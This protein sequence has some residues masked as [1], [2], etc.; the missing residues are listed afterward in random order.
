MATKN[1]STQ[2]RS[3]SKVTTKTLPASA[4]KPDARIRHLRALSA[5]LANH[6]ATLFTT[7]PGATAVQTVRLI[8]DLNRHESRAETLEDFAAFQ[9][10]NMLAHCLLLDAAGEWETF[11][12]GTRDFRDFGER[13]RGIKNVEITLRLALE[14]ISLARREGSTRAARASAPAVSK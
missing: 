4:P 13:Y 3:I 5:K 2:V 14:A 1:R 7:P 11:N 12:K 9:R 6:V 8:D 10:L